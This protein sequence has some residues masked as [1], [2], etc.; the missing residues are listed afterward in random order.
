M[1]EIGNKIIHRIRL[2]VELGQ[3]DSLGKGSGFRS[4]DLKMVLRVVR[5]ARSPIARHTYS[6]VSLRGWVRVRD[7]GTSGAVGSSVKQNPNG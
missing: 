7:R 1:S 6:H 4:T 2:V 5:T 3:G